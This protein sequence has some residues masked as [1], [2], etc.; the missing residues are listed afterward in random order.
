MKFDWIV[1]KLKE[2]IYPYTHADAVIMDDEGT[3]LS[4]KFTEV[5]EHL[6]DTAL[7]V[8][9]DGN[10]GQ[11]LTKT[12][13]GNVWETIDNEA[14]EVVDNLTT[15]DSTKALSAKQGKELKALIDAGSGGGSYSIKDYGTWYTDGHIWTGTEVDD[16][17]FD[18][19][20]NT[21]VYKNILIPHSLNLNVTSIRMRG[22]FSKY[23]STVTTYEKITGVITTGGIEY[24]NYFVAIKNLW[25]ATQTLGKSSFR[26]EYLS[27][28]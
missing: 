2:R 24:D 26:I 11:V 6:A 19:A 13:D 8:P 14:I 7:H 16:R 9:I 5:D 17:D 12:S 25:T 21:N 27:S 18:V 10:V 3:K 1:N 15:D 23:G 20:A 4:D 22:S 28:N